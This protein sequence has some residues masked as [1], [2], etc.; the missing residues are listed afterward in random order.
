MADH[1]R[2]LSRTGAVLSLIFTVLGG[3][4]AGLLSLS[5]ASAEKAPPGSPAAVAT[6]TYNIDDDRQFDNDGSYAKLAA[7]I[8]ASIGAWNERLAGAVQLVPAAAGE[9]ADTQ[10][11]FGLPAT[12]FGIGTS[13]G[14][15]Q[16]HSDRS[17]IVL[18]QALLPEAQDD[19]RMT[20]THEIG[21]RLGLGH[22]VNGRLTTLNS[23]GP[24]MGEG[25]DSGISC[26]RVMR[27]GSFASTETSRLAAADKAKLNAAQQAVD[28]AEEEGVEASAADVALIAELEEER[29][30]N[31][32][33][34]PHD[35]EVNTVKEL[36][37]GKGNNWYLGQNSPTDSLGRASFTVRGQRFDFDGQG[38]F[39]GTY[40]NVTADDLLPGIGSGTDGR[41]L[42]DVAPPIV[43]RSMFPEWA[44][45][46]LR[47]QRSRPGWQ[48]RPPTSVD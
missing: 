36:W 10:F 19:G 43:V 26:T 48:D 21:H 47:E 28:A 7:A 42:E 32:T 30:E 13:F 31:C 24:E 1:K 25:V 41:A 45:E 2:R 33:S 46:Q 29:T 15:H 18:N 3:S 40:Y 16:R 5:S 35:E 12:S 37:R 23:G 9:T 39:Q 22:Y 11:I 34:T 20:I 27:T 44:K 6:I 4:V 8:R 38:G 17:T 14:Y